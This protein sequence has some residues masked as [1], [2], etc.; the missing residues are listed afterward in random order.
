MLNPISQRH[1]RL[2]YGSASSKCENTTARIPAI[3]PAAIPAGLPSCRSGRWSMID[4]QLIELPARHRLIESI[5]AAGLDV[6]LPVRDDGAD[7]I[8]YRRKGEGVFCARP[9]QLKTASK[10]RFAVDRNKYE[11][12]TGLIMAY[13]W[14]EDRSTIYALAYDPDVHEVA[15]AM[16]WDQTDSWKTGGR[17]KKPGWSC[18]PTPKLLRLR[19]PFRGTAARWQMLLEGTPSVTTETR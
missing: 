14:G 2:I 4:T 10:P 3:R 17:R 9:V 1:I 18:Y 16:G 8:V 12:R 19:E 6:A 13:V 11:P 15:R 5:I 7:L